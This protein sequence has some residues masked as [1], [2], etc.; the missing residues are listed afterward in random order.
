MVVL[1]HGMLPTLMISSPGSRETVLVTR[2]WAEPTIT[3]P[4]GVGR[5]L[6]LMM[7]FRRPTGVTGVGR[8]VGTGV[9]RGVGT[10]VGRGVGIG[11]G[12]GIGTGAGRGAGTGVG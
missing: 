10:G 1:L 4:R 7:T 6:I 5:V 11:I 8:G 9:G 3:K 2:T 12:R